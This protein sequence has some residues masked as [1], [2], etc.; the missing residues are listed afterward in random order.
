MT[1]APHPI[2]QGRSV[3]RRVV[4]LLVAWLVGA[5]VLRVTLLAPEV[6]PAFTA[7]EARATAVAAVDWI[8]DNQFDNGRYLY[9]YDRESGETPNQYNLVRHAGTTMA[10]YQLVAAGETEYLAAADRATQYMLDRMVT[11]GDDAAGWAEPGND[12]QLGA[13]ALMTLSL[14]IRREAT[15]DDVFDDELRRLGRFMEGQQLPDGVMLE[16]WLLSTGAPNP[17]QRSRYATGEALWAFAYLHD[18]F[19]GEGWDGAAFRTLD[20][21]SLRR[22]DEEQLF[23][24]PWPDQW[25]AYSLGQLATWDLEDHQ[26]EYAR[27]LAA[28]FGVQV[29]W[30]SQRSGGIATLTHPPEPRGAGFGTVLEGLGRLGVLAA[31]DDRLADLRQPI[32]ERLVCGAAR[33]AAAQVG[34]GD[35]VGAEPE[36]ELGAWFLNDETRMD[37]QQHAASGMLWAEAVLRGGTP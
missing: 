12:L 35:V 29:R 11:T 4:A 7:D 16:R 15:G 3:R 9:L 20:Y 21:L 36:Y 27:S 1:E 5:A 30:D 18:T 25:A 32:E 37:D 28:Q 13:A 17:S 19:P 14:L 22:D 6:C 33:L 10:V 26:I 23:P 34:A 2:R 24:N 31:A 8:V